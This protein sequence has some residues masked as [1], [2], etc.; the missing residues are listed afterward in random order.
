MYCLK[1]IGIFVLLCTS[2]ACAGTGATD[3]DAYG[4]IKE[5]V[6][7]SC[8]NCHDPS[9]IGDLIEAVGALDD[10]Q[11][12]ST[13]FP[14]SMFPEALRSKSAA[15]LADEGI[16]HVSASMSNERAWIINELAELEELLLEDVP[17]DFTTAEGWESF[18]ALEEEGAYEGCEILYRLKWG[19]DANPEGMPPLWAERL[20][21]L[22]GDTG[23]IG[24]DEDQRND[25]ADYVED[26]VPGGLLNCTE[27]AEGDGD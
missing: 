19:R 10:T 8:A 18:I 6:D 5:A 16:A 15:D 9:K 7:Q 4:V 24:I 2:I 1:I 14:S 26:R 27:P 23:Y 13:N 25:I 22:L 21:E 17:P 3:S 12:S 11:L 20:M